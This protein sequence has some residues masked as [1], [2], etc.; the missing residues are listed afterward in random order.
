M[1]SIRETL[2][3]GLDAIIPSALKDDDTASI[4]AKRKTQTK[5]LFIVLSAHPNSMCTSRPDFEAVDRNLIA[6]P[7]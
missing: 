7:V 3:T 5:G 4:K 2:K 1:G 6:I